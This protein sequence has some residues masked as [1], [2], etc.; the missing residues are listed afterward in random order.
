MGKEGAII[1]AK[2]KWKPILVELP[3]PRANSN[4]RQYHSPGKIDDV[5]ATI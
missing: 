3:L 2:A 4:L 1:R 5:C